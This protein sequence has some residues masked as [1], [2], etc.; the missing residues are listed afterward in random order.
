MPEFSNS[1][2]VFAKLEAVR[3]ER[4]GT[5]EPMQ[6]KI[7]WYVYDPAKGCLETQTPPGTP[8][9]ELPQWWTCPE[10]GNGKQVF[11]PYLETDEDS[12]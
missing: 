3:R 9:S 12:E 1:D 7:C 6:C 5:N 10:C 4:M 8:F 2:E 11:F